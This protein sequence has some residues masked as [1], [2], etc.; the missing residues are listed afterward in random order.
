M[1]FCPSQ[2]ALKV[3]GIEVQELMP[4][5]AESFSANAALPEIAIRR[6]CAFEDQRH[7]LLKT[8]LQCRPGL[9]NRAHRG[10]AHELGVRVLSYS[11]QFQWQCWYL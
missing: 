7:A 9:L 3:S 1:Y 2:R 11:R 8:V 5:P 10:K 4:K 6:R